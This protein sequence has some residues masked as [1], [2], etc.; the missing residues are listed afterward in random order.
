LSGCTSTGPIGATY[1]NATTFPFY[2]VNGV[3]LASTNLLDTA[4]IAYKNA[5]NTFTGTQT[6]PIVNVTTQFNVAGVQIASANLSDGA[7]L[8]K[9]NAANIFTGGIQKAA[10]FNATNGFQFNGTATTNHVLLG[11]GTNYVDS[12]TIP[13]SVISG[14]GPF[15]GSGVPCATSTTVSTVCTSPQIVAALNSSPS[16]VL[17][18]V[19][20]PTTGTPGTYISPVSITTDA[21]GR[22]TAAVSGGGTTPVSR[23]CGANGCYKIFADGT[24]EEWGT[25]TAPTAGGSVQTATITY[26]YAFASL[27]ILTIT[28]N[29]GPDGTNNDAMTTYATG[30]STTGAT[31]VIRCATNIGGSGCPNL[32]NAVPVSWQA[33]Y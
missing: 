19:L 29:N 24:I 26:P 30:G 6:A 1:F 9:I 11:N 5:A 10:G 27:P 3:Q 14:G 20:L 25:V 31:V 21:Y 22:V 8:A 15:A 4:N 32:S 13:Y 7:N 18:T 2:E 12:A 33:K 16:T 17:A 23:T 28:A